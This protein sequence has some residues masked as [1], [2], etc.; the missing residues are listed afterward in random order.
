M[1]LSQIIKLFDDCEIAFV[2]RR[3]MVREREYSA[4]EGHLTMTASLLSS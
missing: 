4:V 2:K 1:S 3:P